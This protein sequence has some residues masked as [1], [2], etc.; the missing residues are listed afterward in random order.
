MHGC[1][2]HQHPGC[3]QATKPATRPDFWQAKFAANMKRDAL[4]AEKLTALGWQ[5]ITIWECQT[6]DG[7]ALDALAWSILATE[8]GARRHWTGDEPA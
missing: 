2:W 3:P 1:F 6:R 4:V 7:L 5:V 8:P